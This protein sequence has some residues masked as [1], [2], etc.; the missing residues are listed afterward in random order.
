MFLLQNKSNPG[1][2]LQLY[3]K[4]EF[5]AYTAHKMFS[6]KDFFCKCDKTGSFVRISSYL[7]KKS[8][9]EHLISVQCLKHAFKIFWETKKRHEMNVNFKLFQPMILLHTPEKI[10]K[11]DVFWC[12]QGVGKRII[13]LK[14]IKVY[15]CF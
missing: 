1:L 10:R 4:W 15:I 13:G 2:G 14:W 6:I 7:L 9:M 3:Y 11:P 12:F 5:I 8:F